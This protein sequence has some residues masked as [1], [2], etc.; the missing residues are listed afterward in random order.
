MNKQYLVME[1]D[2]SAFHALHNRN[3]YD[4]RLLDKFI[5]DR[6]PL[7]IEKECM[8]RKLESDDGFAARLRT[9]ERENKELHEINQ[10][11]RNKVSYMKSTV[12]MEGVKCGM[13]STYTRTTIDPNFVTCKRCTA[14]LKEAANDY[15]NTDIH[16]ETTV[17][18]V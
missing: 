7:E 10:K 14:K 3:D 12:H 18:T 15:P 6:N 2:G 17:H 1:Y 16:S 11:L 9:A 13:V 5:M 8:N 4:I